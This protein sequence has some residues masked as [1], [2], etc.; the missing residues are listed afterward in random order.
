MRK[1]EELEFDNTYAGL[2]EAF[3][4]R[5]LPAPFSNPHLVSFN[6]DAAKLIDLDPDEANRPEF[7]EY[8]SGKKTL[9]GAEPVA[10]LYTGHQ[11]GVYN[12]K[13]G[14]GRAIL[15]GEVRN[16]AGAKWDLHLKGAGRTKFSRRFDGRAVLRSTIREYLCGEAM[17]GLGIPTTRALCIIG[18]DEKVERETSET[19]AMLVRMAPSH[20]RFGSLE[21]F[22]YRGEKE[23]LKR[24]A[25]Y[26]IHHHFSHLDGAEDKYRRFLTEVSISTA[27]LIAKWQAAGFAHGVMNTDNMSILGITLDYGPFGF[28]DEYN[29]RLISNHSDHMGRYAFDQQPG[30]AHW[31]LECLAKALSPLISEGQAEEA[32]GAFDPAFTEHYTELVREKLGLKKQMP[33]DK[34]LLDRLLY[35]LEANH[36]DY[37]NFFRALG[38]FRLNADD[39]NS[40]LSDMIGDKEAITDWMNRYRKRLLEEESVDDERRQRMDRVNPKYVLRNYITQ[41]AIIDAEER[42]DYSEIERL[43]K[44]LRNPYEEQPGMERYTAPPPEWSKNLVISCSS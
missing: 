41:K 25:D 12:R 37:T 16:S 14:D 21:A 44:L 30:V 18:S 35:I 40:T 38:G 27:R 4:E 8:T 13:L 33:E 43:L 7:V 39:N 28:M 5:I 32:T 15:L 29:P 19:G 31:N 10:M 1:L 26:V 22:Y 11:F 36:A 24:L 42:N 9:P 17:H 34:A 6:P 20:V 2:P 3:Y 23:H